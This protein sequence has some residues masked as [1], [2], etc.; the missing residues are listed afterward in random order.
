MGLVWIIFQVL[1]GF[2]LVLPLFLYVCSRAK[3]R[4]FPKLSN[5]EYDYAIIITAYQ[6][7]VLLKSVVDSI[8]KMN[9]D[10]Y[11]IYV[12]ADSCDISNLSF[13]PDK[14]ILLRPQ[15]EL[16]NNVR[17]HFYAIEHFKRKHEIL[18]IIDSDNLVDVD[19]LNEL[20]RWFNRGFKAVQG[21]R[22]PKSLD[23]TIARL[24]AIRDMYYHFY[25]GETLFKLGSSATL[26]G[27]GMAFKTTLYKQCLE[28][29][30]VTGAGFD[31]VLQVQIVKKN[32]QIAFAPKAIVY[33]EKTKSSNQL[34]LQRS[35]WINSWFKY[36]QLGFSLIVIGF[37]KKQINPFLFGIVLLRPPLF[38]FLSLSFICL[39]ISVIF[40]SA[41]QIYIWL[42]AFLV[43]FFSFYLALKSQ[44]ATPV[45]YH[46]LWG[47][48]KFVFLQCLALVFA[49][50]A[51]KRSVATKHQ[52]NL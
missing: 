13:C 31:K 43:F 18:T 40:F 19:Y 5:E 45:I 34:I 51:N 8:L 42:I 36:F 11:L 17:S 35:R 12:V 38:I 50:N 44:K 32:I 26:A 48:P 24:D 2:N 3:C 29:L 27:S 20:N 9:Y 4:D 22:K 15:Q 1:L 46:A 30:E 23:T 14:V 28:S 41:L 49:K 47:I 25:D 7:T 39:V 16:A 52:I 33:D 10:N 21:I 6:E 37:K